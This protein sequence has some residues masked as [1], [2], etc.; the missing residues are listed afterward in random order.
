MQDIISLISNVGFPIVV[1]L[2]LLNFILKNY[3][4]IQDKIIDHDEDST[5]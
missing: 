1:V 5:K 2:I 3:N 4:K